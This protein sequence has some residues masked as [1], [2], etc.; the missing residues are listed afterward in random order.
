ML[1][2]GKKKTEKI[3]FFIGVFNGFEKFFNF[4]N[5]LKK[6]K[7]KTISFRDVKILPLL[8]DWISYLKAFQQLYLGTQHN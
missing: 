3:G 6:K 8:E 4:K 7:K 2:P 5:I 1:I